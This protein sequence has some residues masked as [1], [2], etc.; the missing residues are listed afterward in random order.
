MS[1]IA[2][3]QSEITYSCSFWQ[4]E[5]HLCRR[6]LDRSELLKGPVSLTWQRL[7]ADTALL[8]QMAYIL[9]ITY[10]C[11]HFAIKM[12][13]L[14]LYRR[15]FTT[16][17]RTFRIML[18]SVMAYITGWSISALFVCIF[19]CTP[20]PF[21]WNQAIGLLGGPLQSGHCINLVA[22]QSGIN[23]TNAVAD[24]LILTLPS[25]VLWKLKL[26]TSRKIALT[27]IFSLG[28]L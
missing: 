20:I 28:A 13:I 27:A 17:D 8:S 16:A 26:S 11:V 19:A 6:S 7:D 23:V 25:L 18:Y 15:I 22:A 21:Y 10:S 9:S 5:A 14:L 1:Y 12:S 4:W 3:S 2:A 24:L